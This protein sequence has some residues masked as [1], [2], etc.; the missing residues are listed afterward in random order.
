MCCTVDYDVKGKTTMFVIEEK[1]NQRKLTVKSER[2]ANSIGSTYN[3]CRFPTYD[4]SD[5]LQ[6]TWHIA[7][8]AK[9]TSVLDNAPIYSLWLPHGPSMAHSLGG[10][11]VSAAIGRYRRNSQFSSS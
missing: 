9:E 10:A 8:L 6:V 2:A 1:L 3:N 7:M 4:N 5:V 11:L